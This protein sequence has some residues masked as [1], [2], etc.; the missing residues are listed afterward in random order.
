MKPKGQCLSC[1]KERNIIYR[2]FKRK[3]IVDISLP[4]K[5]AKM[6]EMRLLNALNYF[7]LFTKASGTLQ[8]HLFFTG[9]RYRPFIFSSPG[10]IILHC[11]V[12]SERFQILYSQFMFEPM[13]GTE[14]MKFMLHLYKKR[15]REPQWL[16]FLTPVCPA[17]T[18]FRISKNTSTEIV[19]FI[20]P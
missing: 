13:G 16:L 11:F 18:A 2:N 19:Q 5:Q 17:N 12:T 8:L 4:L 10:Y 20:I 3:K 15:W 9:K 14:T 1:G 7:G 6:K